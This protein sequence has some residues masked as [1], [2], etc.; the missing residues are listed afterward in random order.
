[1]LGGVIVSLTVLVVGGVLA[2]DAATG[3]GLGWRVALAWGLVVLGLGLLVGTWWG[4]ARSVSAVAVLTTLVLLSTVSYGVP[5]RGGV[6]ERVWEPTSV[7]QVRPSY[8]L[9]AG[10]LVLDLRALDVPAGTTVAVEATVAAGTVLV[11]L[12]ADVGARVRG[13]AGL[14]EVDLPGQPV[15]SGTGPGSRTV[16]GGLGVETS[17]VSRPRAARAGTVDLDLSVGV[18]TVEVRRAAS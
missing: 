6:G 16:S 4:R 14:G 10:L 3:S 5:L 13:E 18:G 1:M 12:P 7:A 9:A 15:G 17:T 2:W 8:E 11:Q